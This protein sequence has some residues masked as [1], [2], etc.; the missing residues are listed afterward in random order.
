M[1]RGKYLAAFKSVTTFIFVFILTCPAY[2]KSHDSE[3]KKAESEIP[4]DTGHKKEKIQTEQTDTKHDTRVD[5]ADPRLEDLERQIARL[6][7]E[8]RLLKEAEFERELAEL[9]RDAQSAASI[10]SASEAET[11]RTVFTSGNRSLQAL[12]P[13]ISLTSD[14]GG[15]LVSTDYDMSTIPDDSGF[16][17]RMIG[18]HF[19][20]NLDPYSFTKIAVGITPAGVGFGEGYATWVG[21]MPNMNL[22]VGK[23]RQLFGIINRW[24]TPSMDQFDRPLVLT[25]LLGSS[26]LNAIGMSLEWKMPPLLASSHTLTVEITN[27]MN[28]DLFT[29][30]MVGIPTGLVRLRNYWDTGKSTYL[31][32]GLSGHAGYHDTTD[33]LGTILGGMDLTFNWTPL[34][35]ERYRGITWRSELIALQKYLSDDEILAI[36]AYSYIQARL[37]RTLEVG[38]RGDLTQSPDVGKTDQWSYQLV[39]YLTWYQSPWVKIRLQASDLRPAE[40]DSKQSLVMQFVWSVGP[41]KHDRY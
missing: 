39:P 9:A 38:F 20:A 33:M 32:L 7:E 23:F 36:G 24:H 15:K 16:L 13:E 8:I 18:L 11:R 2:A 26:G 41:H 21:F 1:I 4:D 12:N 29:G 10:D 3:I 37:S 34:A 25:Q 5:R 17:F 27:P 28:S 6:T 30:S 40:G 31:E 14:A 19:E 22:T 35:R